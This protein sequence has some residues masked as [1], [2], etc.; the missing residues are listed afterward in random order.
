[1]EGNKLST[2]RQ[3]IVIAN[4]VYIN[5]K[6]K[7]A[8][9]HNQQF[10]TQNSSTMKSIFVLVLIA[11][12]KPAP[13]KFLVVDRDMKKPVAYAS[14]FTTE[15]YLHRNFPVYTSEVK[16]LVEA[17]DKAVKRLGEGFTCN[18]FEKIEA[19]HTSIMIYQRCDDNKRLSI[20]LVTELEG[21]KTSFSFALVVNETEIQRAQRKLL[22]FATYI[23]Q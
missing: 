5:L 14:Q 6:P 23:N 20:T 13:A 9:C 22:D 17:A 18:E 3:K 11:L 1:L 16:E 21:T 10:F 15:L 19:G 4:G 8:H 7:A 12:L 2:V